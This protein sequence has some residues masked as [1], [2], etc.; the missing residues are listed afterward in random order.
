MAEAIGPDT[1]GTIKAG[2]AA[3]LQ[4]VHGDDQPGI[5]PVW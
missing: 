3:Y 5:R 4:H 1:V 2:L